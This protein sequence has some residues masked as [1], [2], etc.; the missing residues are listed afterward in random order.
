M[1]D[2]D[3]DFSGFRAERKVDVPPPPKPNTPPPAQPKSAG[4]KGKK[5]KKGKVGAQETPP[6]DTSPEPPVSQP[7]PPPAHGPATSAKASGRSKSGRKK[8]V[9]VSL[10]VE[11]S[12]RFTD[13]ASEEDRYL[14]DMVLDAYRDHYAGIRDRFIAEQQDLDLPFRPRRRKAASGRVTHM[15]YL[16]APEIAVIDGS[17]VETGMSR[18]ELVAQLLELELE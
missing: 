1:T 18:S 7:E 3:L 16:A 14:T 2:H 15:L 4:K 10:P 17:A 11:L 9:N 12:Q 8:R 6:A 13:R 5:G